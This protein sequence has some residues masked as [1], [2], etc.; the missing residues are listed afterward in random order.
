MIVHPTPSDYGT[1]EADNLSR[2]ELI[3]EIQKGIDS[4]KYDKKYTISKIFSE[5]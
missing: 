5:S 4:A 1:V 2:D 3:A